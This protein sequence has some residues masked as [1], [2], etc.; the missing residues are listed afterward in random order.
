MKLL[1]EIS[2]KT[3]GLDET[4][5]ILGTE[6]EL[7]KSARVI[8]RKSDSTI[9]IQYLQNHFLHKLPGGGVE[10]GESIEDAAVRE[11]REEVGCDIRL[12]SRVGV[13]IEYRKEHELLHISYCYTADVVGG[14]GTTELEQAEK[15]EG[16]ITVWLSPEDAIKKMELDAPNTYQ[17]PF[18]TQR[19]LAFLKEYSK[20]TNKAQ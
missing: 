1:A 6:Y 18:I 20:T 5:E 3:L 10:P 16:M 9:A 4:F 13:V 8:L 14:I 19:E 11:A 7:R 17:G 15:D 2:D 12:I